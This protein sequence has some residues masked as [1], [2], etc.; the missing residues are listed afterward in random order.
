MGLF[1]LKYAFK[2]L[3][4]ETDGIVNVELALNSFGW[5]LKLSSMKLHRKSLITQ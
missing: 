1:A 4:V 3:I 5:Q 2:V